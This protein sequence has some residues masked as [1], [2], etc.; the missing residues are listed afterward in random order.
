MQCFGVCRTRGCWPLS[1]IEIFRQPPFGARL[2]RWR[3][4][5]SFAR[6]LSLG[7]GVLGR[8][9]S[10]VALHASKASLVE[11]L[12]SATAFSHA[13]RCSTHALQAAGTSD[14][15]DL[16]FRVSPVPQLRREP[17]KAANWLGMRL[18]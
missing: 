15:S 4:A 18:P 6:H 13:S 1:V 12:L 14:R 7:A 10:A 11:C 2:A 3:S 17:P 16:G 5:D 8:L 9:A